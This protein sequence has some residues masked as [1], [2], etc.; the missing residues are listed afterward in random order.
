LYNYRNGAN[1]VNHKLIL[2]RVTVSTKRLDELNIV[3]HDGN[4]IYGGAK[5]VHMSRIYYFGRSNKIFNAGTITAQPMNQGW[6]NIFDPLEW[7][8]SCNPTT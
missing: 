7:P 3:S 1:P 5:F 2:G 8:Y 4:N 6:I